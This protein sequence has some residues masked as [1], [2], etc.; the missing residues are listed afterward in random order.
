MKHLIRKILKESEWFEELD[1]RSVEF[2]HNQLRESRVQKGG[3][4]YWPQR[5]WIGWTRYVDKNGNLLF[6]E[7]SGDLEATRKMLYFSRRID[8]ALDKMGLNYDSIRKICLDTFRE[9]YGLEFDD[10]QLDYF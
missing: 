6:L 5:Q 8:E 3:S 2:L 10:A 7:N 9:V 4:R 1:L